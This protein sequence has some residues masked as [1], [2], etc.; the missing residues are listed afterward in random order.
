M[1]ANIKIRCSSAHHSYSR[2]LACCL[3]RAFL[4]AGHLIILPFFLTLNAKENTHSWGIKMPSAFEMN[5]QNPLVW[6]IHDFSWDLASALFCWLSQGNCVS[7]VHSWNGLILRHCF[8]MAIVPFSEWSIV[9]IVFLSG[10]SF[11]HGYHH[12]RKLKNQFLKCVTEIK[13]TPFYFKTGRW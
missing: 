3:L 2:S 12:Q 13:H 11:Y 6:K 10:A 5:L 4:S 7:C 1:H 8:K 9:A